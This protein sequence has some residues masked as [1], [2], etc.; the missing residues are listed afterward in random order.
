MT[1]FVYMWHKFI[2]IIF[3]DSS[4]IWDTALDLRLPTYVQY[5]LVVS[6]MV[7]PEEHLWDTR[8]SKGSYSH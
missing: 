8:M 4:N 2:I 5:M 1:I 7:G 3:S 6:S